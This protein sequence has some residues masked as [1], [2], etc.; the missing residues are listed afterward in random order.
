[1]KNQVLDGGCVLFEFPA[2]CKPAPIERKW[3]E[4]N[5]EEPNI[6]RPMT[7][8]EE[9]AAIA[10][11]GVEALPE[12][13]W[14]FVRAMVERRRARQRITGKQGKYLLDLAQSYLDVG[15]AS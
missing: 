11:Y 13:H 14:R 4:P 1:M 7:E 9:A 6:W 3:P 5:A 15:Q 8:L 12:R 10:L 2:R